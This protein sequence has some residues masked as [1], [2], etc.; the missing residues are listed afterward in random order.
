MSFN[1]KMIFLWF[2][3]FCF[4]T[5][6][7]IKSYAG[8]G[9]YGGEMY[10]K[11]LHGSVYKFY[12]V[13]YSNC[14]GLTPDP[15]KIEITDGTTTKL[16]ADTI[17]CS[18]NYNLGFNSGQCTLCSGSCSFAFGI[19]FITYYATIDVGSFSGCNLT[20]SFSYCCSYYK[21]TTGGGNEEVY[22]NCKLNRC[23]GDHNAPVFQE[24]G[25]FLMNVSKPVDIYQTA[26]PYNINDSM[27]YR[28]V[29]PLKDS[30]HP[31][32][33]SAGY[34][35][36]FPMTYAGISPTDSIPG[37][38]HYFQ[39][40]GRLFFVPQQTDESLMS[41]E[42]DEYAK[43]SSG[44]WYLAGTTTKT[45]TL[46]CSKLKSSNDLPQVA[47]I[48]EA[49][50]DTLYTCAGTSLAIQ[51][52][53][54]DPDN[55]KDTMV[56]MNIVNETG[57]TFNFNGNQAEGA[58]FSWTPAN[59]NV[60]KQPYKIIMMAEDALYPMGDFSQKAFYI[61]VKDSMPVFSIK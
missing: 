61:V 48:K 42:A 27:V 20:A 33:F 11:H 30:I 28:L 31:T 34:E 52:K 47:P 49:P 8:N 24:P 51:F 5:V 14:T 59:A 2:I 54:T 43:N 57:G 53:T 23:N 19:Q 32:T 37:G 38:F 10:Y 46:I 55:H 35:Y 3:C 22:V 56:L 13:V 58:L 36:S 15:P 26:T 1:Y 17:C 39:N 44:N 40:S 41:I 6:N 50:N 7:S 29:P 45:L 4:L 60:R 12:M 9:F 18:S 21:I 25:Q 16:Y